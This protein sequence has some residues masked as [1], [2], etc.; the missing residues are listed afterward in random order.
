MVSWN[1]SQKWLAAMFAANATRAAT[2]FQ[3]SETS[4]VG[5]SGQGHVDN[6]ST[7][8]S[9]QRSNQTKLALDYWTMRLRSSCMTHVTGSRL[10]GR[11]LSPYNFGSPEEGSHSDAATFRRP[12]NCHP[13]QVR[14]RTSAVRTDVPAKTSKKRMRPWPWA[15]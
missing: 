12:V 15:V 13:S 11:L 1:I 7:G 3:Q 8:G 10:D 9:T 14:F 4:A 6:F 5:G 2:G